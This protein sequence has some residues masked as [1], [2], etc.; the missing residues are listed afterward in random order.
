MLFAKDKSGRASSTQQ[1]DNSIDFSNKEI[2]SCFYLMDKS[3]LT[4]A[5]MIVL[6]ILSLTLFKSTKLGNSFK[7]LVVKK[8]MTGKKKTKGKAIRKFNF[9]KDMIKVTESIIAGTHFKSVKHIG[10]FKAI[11]MASSGYYTK[12]AISNTRPSKLVEFNRI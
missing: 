10:K 1:F 5:K 2:T 9:D 4:P 7:K 12:Q 3:M 11:H 8:L 6:R